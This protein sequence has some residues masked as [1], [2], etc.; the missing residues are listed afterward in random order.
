MS[1]VAKPATE[2]EAAEIVRAAA[3]SET[4]LSIEGGG[5]KQELGGPIVADQTISSANLSGIINYDP[6][7]MV[8][9]AFAGTP[10]G[11]IET[12]LAKH[13]QRL[14]F[15]PIDYRPLLAAN[16]SPTIGA[17]AAINNSGPRRF[18]SGAARDS[19]LGVRFI[20]G[21]G[22]IVKNG[23]RVMKNVTGL[24]LV[25]LMAGSWGTLGFMTEVTF[26]VLPVPETEATL[27]L[28]GLDDEQATNAMAHA[29]ATSAEVSGAAHLPETVAAQVLDGQA[30]TAFRLEGFAD[31]VASRIK[32]LTAVFSAPGLETVT[33]DRSAG[34]WKQIRDAGFFAGKPSIVWRISMQPSEAHKFVMALRMNA[35]IDASYDWQGGL[36]WL[37]IEDGN[38][39][40]D[41]I[42]AELSRHGGGHAM[43]V[44]AG[45]DIRALVP[46]FQPQPAG[47]A[48]LSER[49]G[50]A[51]DPHGVFN[52]G[53]MVI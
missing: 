30:A 8:F 47:L 49:I 7:E 36:V 13:N 44:R 10:L 18:V 50:K 6:A 45:S 3:A 34:L 2:T 39:H 32:R 1:A 51:F 20:N 4:T 22:D 35:A 12:E 37:S 48:G 27:L 17:V 26:K 31:S 28:R 33:G 16:G 15:E 19:L 9:T 14:A 25:K 5:T 53:R 24:D 21:R 29:M 38:P 52:T 43:L 23:G 11:D 46:V 42:R 41:L 40:D